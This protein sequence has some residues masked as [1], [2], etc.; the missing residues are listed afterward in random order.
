MAR[1]ASRTETSY[2]HNQFRRVG[3]RYSTGIRRLILLSMSFF[4]SFLMG[5]F[6]C[7]THRDRIRRLDLIRSTRHDELALADYQRLVSLGLKTARDGV[8]W[9]LIETEPGRYDFS[10]LDDQ[11]Q[12]AK[13][14]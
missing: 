7:S 1:Y 14:T 8:R 12:A 10:S 9:H 6:E 13:A 5:G 3:R 4:S 2:F 11:I